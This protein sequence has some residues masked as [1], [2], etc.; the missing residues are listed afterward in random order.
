MG[1]GKSTVGRIVAAELDV[2]LV[3]S[4][5][6][7][8]GRLG[9]TGR[10][11]A[12]QHGVDQL[13]LAEAAALERALGATE[14]TVIAAAASIGDRIDLV[15]ALGAD[16]ILLVLMMGKPEVLAERTGSGGHRR[17]FDLDEFRRS[18]TRRADLVAP[19]ADLIV[20]VTTE[21]PDQIAT[22]ILAV[23]DGDHPP[24]TAD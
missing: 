14:P 11:L 21:T 15:A 7:I 17:R 13:H 3:D 12:A 8:E 1:S 5:A 2:P 4:D 18:A 6:Q 24:P 19:A 23:A 20:D 9:V 16:D 22:R 10:R